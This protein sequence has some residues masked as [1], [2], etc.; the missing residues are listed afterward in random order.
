MSVTITLPGDPVAKGRPRF[1]SRAGV[2]MVYTPAKTLHYESAL[3][4]KAREV[5]GGKP[6]MR[7]PVSVEMLAQIAI[8]KSWPVTKRTMA[9]VGEVTPGK[10]D[11]DNYA[12]IV[13][14]ALNGVVWVDDAQVAHLNA[15]KKYG[16]PLLVVTVR[17]A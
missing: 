12:K 1:A 14:D 7:G 11:I 2:P 16:D 9:L 4:A 13:G 10:P 3:R 5:M 17:A 8:P 15:R 6:P